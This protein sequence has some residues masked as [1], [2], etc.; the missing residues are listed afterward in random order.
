MEFTRVEK[1]AILRNSI[2]R[3]LLLENPCDEIMT[4]DVAI[5]ENGTTQ[6]DFLQ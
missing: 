4:K 2:F 1:A 3:E 6:E 5:F